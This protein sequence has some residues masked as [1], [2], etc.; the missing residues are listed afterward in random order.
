MKLGEVLVVL[1]KPSK[2][3]PE[4]CFLNFILYMKHDNVTK[5]DASMWNWSKSALCDDALFIAS[6]INNALDNEVHWP[7]V[8]EKVSLA[9]HL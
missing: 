2:L 1:N 5:Y 6:C 7:I 8:E 3:T 9:T 4:Q